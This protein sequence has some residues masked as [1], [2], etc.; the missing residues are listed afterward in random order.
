MLCLSNQLPLKKK[1]ERKKIVCEWILGRNENNSEISHDIIFSIAPHTI[2]GRENVF[3]LLVYFLWYQCIACV[4][5]IINKNRA[6]WKRCTFS[7]G[8]R[9]VFSCVCTFNHCFSLCV[10]VCVCYFVL[11]HD[12]ISPI[13][14]CSDKIMRNN[15]LA[16]FLSELVFIYVIYSMRSGGYPCASFFC[17]LYSMLML[18]QMVWKNQTTKHQQH[19][20]QYQALLLALSWCLYLSQSVYAF[21]DLLFLCDV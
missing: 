12:A 18:N 9:T 11:L 3:F 15:D 21:I 6:N 1:E 17:R 20:H 10:C 19:Q 5:V 4:S 16:I 8:E 13:V 7:D 14:S 2:Y